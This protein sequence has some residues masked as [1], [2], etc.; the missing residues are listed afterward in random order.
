MTEHDIDVVAIGKAC[1]GSHEVGEAICDALDGFAKKNVPKERIITGVGR[2]F[3]TILTQNHLFVEDF[4][5]EMIDDQAKMV[6]IHNE[7]APD[8]D[9]FRRLS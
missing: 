2:A 7:M 9:A 6:R 1:I 3:L 4:F 8:C 5:A